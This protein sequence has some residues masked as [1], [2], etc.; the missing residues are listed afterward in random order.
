MGNRH[1]AGYV[2]FPAQN[3]GR[4]LAAG[5]VPH[6]AEFINHWERV[7]LS[8]GG[9]FKDKPT[10]RRIP[11]SNFLA[12]AHILP[13]PRGALSWRCLNMTCGNPPLLTG[14]G[15]AVATEVPDPNQ[16]LASLSR[17]DTARLS[18]SLKLV[19]LRQ[20]LVF[21]QPGD[22]IEHVYFPHTG[23]VSLLAVMK[24]GRA[25]ET[26]VVGREGVVG[27]I[28]GLGLHIALT[29]AVVQAPL[30]AL[31]IAAVPFRKA[32]QASHALRDLIIRYNDA[33]LGQVQMTAACYALHSIQARLAR[34]ILQTQDRVD[35]DTVPLTQELLSA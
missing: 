15:A 12:S 19:S 23:M 9:P 8:C 11:C 10:L 3:A 16:L 20:G 31:Q 25:V 30:V 6:S 21:H 34:W 27:A 32:V 2:R 22:E 33:L 4:Q 29:R 1:S 26:A 24:D 13:R 5:P 18:P 7:Y 35:T 14:E 28:A 17:A